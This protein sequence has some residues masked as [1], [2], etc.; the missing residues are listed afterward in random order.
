[1][2]SGIVI[3][4]LRTEHSS[5][6]PPVDEWSSST[7]EWLNWRNTLC[8][9]QSFRACSPSLPVFSLNGPVD[10]PVPPTTNVMPHWADWLSEWTVGHLTEGQEDSGSSSRR[11]LACVLWVAD[12]QLLLPDTAVPPCRVDSAWCSSTSLITQNGEK[13]LR[14]REGRVSVANVPFS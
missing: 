4:V 12:C 13:G 14:T 8:D 1:M 11:I 9:W 7:R 10:F 5:P 3:S 2:F 6:T